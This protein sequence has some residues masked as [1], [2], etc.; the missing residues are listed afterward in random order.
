MWARTRQRVLLKLSHLCRVSHIPKSILASAWLLA[1]G[2]TRLQHG[3]NPFV[4][5][6]VVVLGECVLMHCARRKRKAA[7]PMWV[8]ARLCDLAQPIVVYR[9]K[10]LR[11]M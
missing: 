5:R 10:T 6:S 1:S 3:P 7:A 2:W 8:R 11:G 4:R 9:G